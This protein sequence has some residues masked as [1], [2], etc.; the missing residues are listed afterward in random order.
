MKRR[1]IPMALPASQRGVTL[2]VGMIMLVLI[3]LLVL[4]S[5]Q[6]GRTNLE[7][8]GN[9]QQRAEGLATAQQT[10]EAAF[11]SPLLTSSP[12]AIFPKPC[13]GFGNNNTLCYDVNGDGKNDVVVQVTP[14]PKCIKAQPI[15]ATSLNLADP[16]DQQCTL[17]VSQGGFGTGAANNN[18]NCANTVWDIRAVAQ[19]LDAG[20]AAPASQGPTAVIDQGI[21]VRV[22]TNEVESSCP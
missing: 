4:A 15:P 2:L 21:A 6:L 12:D 14:P 17:G 7:I 16:N 11:T 3:T 10:I 1:R 13:P 9:A 5:Y 18:S 22:G 8:V 19:N 20:G